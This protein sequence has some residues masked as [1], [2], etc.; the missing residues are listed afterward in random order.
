MAWRLAEKRIKIK[1]I[2]NKNLGIKVRVNLN[3]TKPKVDRYWLLMVKNPNHLF[4][5]FIKKKK[6]SLIPFG[7][8]LTRII[9]L[10]FKKKGILTHTLNN[11]HIH[12]IIYVH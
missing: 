11:Y 10:L 4:F 9:S 12:C 3:N 5:A 8:G 1:Q 7:Q 2:E 6:I